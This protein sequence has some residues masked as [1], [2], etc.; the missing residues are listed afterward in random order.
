MDGYILLWLF[1]IDGVLGAI[2]ETAYCSIWVY[3]GVF[4]SRM[5]LVYVPV[6]PLYG[7]GGVV[8]TLTLGGLAQ[9]PILV[10]LAGLLLCSAAEFVA[11]VVLQRVFGAIFWDY[12]DKRFNLRGRVCLESALV[13]GIAS[14]LVVYVLDPAS[15]RLISWIPRQIGEIGL[16]VLTGLTLTAV[17]LTAATFARL[18]R[19]VAALERDGAEPPASVHSARRQHSEE[20]ERP[21]RSAPC[22]CSTVDA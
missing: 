5:A 12:S 21:Y 10:F 19:R 2:L 17:T 14:L 18:R 13:W 22:W 4:T 9:W 20:E 11:S 8:L 6:H 7:A 15:L 16:A 1:F 3:R